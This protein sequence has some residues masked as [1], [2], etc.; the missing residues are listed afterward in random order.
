M[1]H[2]TNPVIKHKAGLLNLAEELSNVSKACKI[3]GV[4]RDTFYRYRELADEG[5][6]DALINRSRR[7]PNLKNR[8]DE[9]TEQAVVD[10]AV[11]FPAHGQHRTSNEL[12][13]Q[14][15][16]ISG[17]GVRSV[18]LRHNLEK[19]KKRLKAL[20][21]KA[22]DDEA[23]GEI[24]TAHPGYLGSQDTFY[25]GN[26]KCV[27]R[28]YQRTFVDTYSKVAHCKPYVTKTPI[29]A[30]DL[31]NDRVLPF[32]ASQGLP[33]LR[34]LTDRG[35]EY[36]GKVEQ[37]DY[38]LYLAI[39]DIEHTKTKAMFPQTNGICERFHKTILNEFYQVTF[40]KK[41]YGD[42]DTLQSDL[43][44]WLAHYN[45]ERTHQGKMCNGRTPMETLLDGKR[46][47]AEKNLNQ[48]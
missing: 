18:W 31:L 26:L 15:V 8:I 35:T 17:S 27:G 5:G 14:G 45:N 20:E 24:E 6:V 39:N 38:Q 11:A 2:T 37:H 43:D 28:I 48:M 33:I 29:T 47:W 3:M 44:E 23:C 19:F 9:A 42:L 32:Y 4:S 10:Y 46:I 34:I 7:A 21:R 12:R 22:S 30:A 16:F 1:L 40:R 25:V 41:L 36:C 13:K